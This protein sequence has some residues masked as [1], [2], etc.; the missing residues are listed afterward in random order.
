MSRQQQWTIGLMSGS[1]PLTLTEMPNNP[2][3]TAE[4]VTDVKAE[5]V[6]DPFLL[7]SNDQWYLFFE[8][9]PSAIDT[10]A[11]P[12]VIG[13]ARSADLT[14]WEYLGTVLKEPWHLSYP[15][16][17]ELDGSHYMLPETL[18]ADHVRLYQS[19]AFPFDW[20]PI[21]DLIP[22]QHADPSLF[23]YDQTWWLFTC[24][25]PAEHNV[26]A[27][28]FAPDLTGPWQAHP[29]S[30]LLVDDA[31]NAR[32]AGRVLIWQDRVYRF[33]Q[34]CWPRYGTQVCMFEITKLSRTHYHEQE[35]TRSPI[36]TP[37]GHGWNGRNMHHIDPHC[38]DGD[39]WIACVDGYYADGDQHT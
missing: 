9:Q 31:R 5:F 12:G 2:V 18:G 8:T 36:L 17:F 22:G 20:Q 13:V 7:P 39:H 32:P 28:D 3:L 11:P 6:A 21:A 25:N 15:Y 38:V 23:Y 24:P 27:L 4:M 37:T 29:M 34:D 10:C 26:L 19:H 14:D 1:T 35:V 16:V 30:P 33:A